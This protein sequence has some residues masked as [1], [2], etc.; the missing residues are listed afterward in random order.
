MLWTL[1]NNYMQE[2]GSHSA[3][4][5][6]LKAFEYNNELIVAT[7]GFDCFL[8][9]WAAQNG[10]LCKL[11][12]TNLA[13]PI[14]YMAC[15]FPLLITAHTGSFLNFFNI[16]QCLV[17]PNF[18]EPALQKQIS[19]R[20]SLSSIACMKNGKGFACGTVTGRIAIQFF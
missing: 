15:E 14:H 3:P 19:S 18:F 2:I 16:E 4:L 10:K 6:D 1:R 20:N 17:T 12:Q 9:L 13:F 5:K 8:C 11:K 7:A